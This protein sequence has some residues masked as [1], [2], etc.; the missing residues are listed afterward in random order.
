MKTNS[1]SFIFVLLLVS[2]QIWS[3]QTYSQ[4]ASSEPELECLPAHIRAAMKINRNRKSLYS[5]RTNGRSDLVS[6]KLLLYEHL[7]L[8]SSERILA[9]AQK[10]NEVGIPVGCTEFVSMEQ[11]PAFSLDQ[12]VPIQPM[13][14]LDLSIYRTQIRELVNKK[15]FSEIMQL[16]KFY[17]ENVLKQ[18]QYYCFT[19]H[20][21]ESSFNIAKWAIRFQDRARAL[22]LIIDPTDVSRELLRLHS[23]FMFFVE[24]LDINASSIQAEGWPI[25][26]QDLPPISIGE[27]AAGK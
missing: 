11:T 16:N 23:D 14:N 13:N 24:N 18:P 22:K 10:F 25:V 1:G 12:T 17:L 5:Q 7:L 21:M 20:I 4:A 9:D 15:L 19:R 26:C 6:G 8:M 27:S 2:L 3:L